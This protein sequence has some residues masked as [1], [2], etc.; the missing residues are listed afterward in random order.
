[1]SYLLNRSTIKFTPLAEAALNLSYKTVLF[2]ALIR[3]THSKI[4]NLVPNFSYHI[5]RNITSKNQK[6]I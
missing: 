4:K 5:N 1:M 3:Y 2:L 6:R